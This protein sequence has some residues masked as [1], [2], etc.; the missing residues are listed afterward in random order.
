MFPISCH[1]G[2]PRIREEIEIALAQI[3]LIMRHV[4]MLRRHPVEILAPCGNSA[5]RHVS[6][7]LTDYNDDDDNANVLYS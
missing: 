4:S 1:A 2:I 6:L 7:A 3:H 5:G